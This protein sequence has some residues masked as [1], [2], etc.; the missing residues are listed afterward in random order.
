MAE[1]AGVKWERASPAWRLVPVVCA[2]VAVACACGAGQLPSQGPHATPVPASLTTPAPPASLADWQKRGATEV[3]PPEVEVVTLAGTEVVNQTGGA[4]SDR[5]ARAWAEGFVRAYQLVLWA[6]NRGQDRFLLTSGLSSAAPAVF[7][8]N[9]NDILQARKAGA[10]VEYSREVF[11]RLVLRP[12]PPAMQSKFQ[13]E[14]FTWKQ[15]AFFLDVVG[16]VS[17]AWVDGQGNRSVRSQIADGVPA[18]ELVGGEAGHDPLMSDVWVMG[19]DWTCTSDST[20][21]GLAPLCNP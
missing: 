18:Y 2:A 15:Y 19:S 6:V 9:F 11:R 12:V 4:V 16:P 7:R 13:A 1:C 20:R 17:I 8:P 10:R 5:D 3:P 21:A 14:Q